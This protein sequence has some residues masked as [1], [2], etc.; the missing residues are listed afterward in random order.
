MYAVMGI[1]G[2]VGGEVARTLL[3]AG[4]SVRAVV[5]SADKGAAWAQRGCDVAIADV[6][7]R[8]AMA[9]A[10]SGVE[11][12]F[13][14]MPSNFDPSPGFPETRQVVENIRLALAAARPGKVVCLSTIGAQATQP[15]LLNQLQLLEQALTNLQS[16]VTFLRPAWFMENA[17]WDVE[18]A[19]GSGMIPSFLQPLDKPVPMIATAD[20]GRVAAELLQASWQGKRIVELEGPQRITP[21]QLGAAFSA[22]L[23]KPVRM[24][25]VPRETW[26]A[27][28]ASQG[29]RNPLPRMQMI[30]GFNEGWIEFEGEPRKGRVELLTVLE[31]LVSRS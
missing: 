19:M 3:A 16:P 30:D 5:R 15:N 9:R 21:L 24:Q 13:V 20:V 28:F 1:T 31:R 18:H 22:L 10:F 8:D 6:D 25:S 14:M 4:H 17:Q 26:Q 11:G 23:G 29:M 12:V 7:D 27:L 2:Q